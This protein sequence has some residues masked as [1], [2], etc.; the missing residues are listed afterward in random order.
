MYTVLHDNRN[1]EVYKNKKQ[2]QQKLYL[3]IVLQSLTKNKLS[4]FCCCC[5]KYVLVSRKNEK[6]KSKNTH[7]VSITQDEKHKY[8]N[9]YAVVYI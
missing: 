8:G 3:K 6:C 2:T 9:I 1:S 5:Q 4:T 7:S